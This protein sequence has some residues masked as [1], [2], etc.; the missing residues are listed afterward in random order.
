MSA[1]VLQCQLEKRQGTFSLSVDLDIRLDCVTAIFGESGSGKT[2]LLRQISG[3]DRAERGRIRM[4][5]DVW[6]D[7]AQKT[8][9]PPHK[10]PVGM[11]FQ[12]GRL[13]PERTVIS[14]LHFAEKRQQTDTPAH[15]FDAVVTAFDLAGLLPQKSDTLSGGERQRVAL[16]QAV[17]TNPQILLLDEPLIGL[18]RGRKREILPY[19][20]QLNTKFNLPILYVSHDLEEVSWLADEVIALSSGS[21]IGQGVP[22]QV[23]AELGEAGEVSKNQIG[24]VVYGEVAEVDDRLKIATVHVGSDALKLPLEHSSSAGSKLRTFVHA[25]DVAIATERPRGISMQ[26]CLEGTIVRIDPESETGFC[27]VHMECDACTLLA[28]ITHLSV[29]A[30]GLSIGKRGFAL[31]KAGRRVG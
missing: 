25:D 26:N 23:V 24:S 7:S 31:F 12:R 20:K 11:V 18:D 10:R 16:A 22:E 28:R 8:F 1:E 19:L 9:L 3:L 4:G 27:I 13:L 6:L 21:V 29:Q 2:T 30:L 17:L 5:S 14:N 15:S